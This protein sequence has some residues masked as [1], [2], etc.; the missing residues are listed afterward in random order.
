[1]EYKCHKSHNVCTKPDSFQMDEQPTDFE[2]RFSNGRRAAAQAH[3][4]DAL[5]H[6]EA[7]LKEARRVEI[8]DNRLCELLNC[9]TDSYQASY[10]FAEAKSSLNEAVDTACD[11]F[12]ADS[13]QAVPYLQKQGWFLCRDGAL[14]ESREIYRR[15][16][17]TKQAVLGATHND[18]G[19]LY[20]EWANVEW[21]WGEALVAQS[22]FDKAYEILS[23]NLALDDDELRELIEQ[24]A[25]FL[26]FANKA[27]EA[28][29]LVNQ[30]LD[31]LARAK[32]RRSTITALQVKL[33]DLFRF[34]GEYREHLHE[35]ITR[36]LSGFSPLA[37]SRFWVQLGDQYAFPEM[38]RTKALAAYRKSLDLLEDVVGTEHV[39]LVEPLERIVSLCLAQE[40]SYSI[41]CCERIVAI[42]EKAKGSEHSDTLNALVTLAHKHYLA[43]NYADANRLY[44]IVVERFDRYKCSDKCPVTNALISLAVSLHKTK[45]FDRSNDCLDRAEKILQ[46]LINTVTANATVGGF[47]F[48]Q[49][50]RIFN[51]KLRNYRA[52]NDIA[53]ARLEEEKL[54]SIRPG[55][56]WA[57]LI[58][59]HKRNKL[60]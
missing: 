60:F 5:L 28:A 22:H 34:T 2:S 30:Y 36:D 16:V 49:L 3:H 9:L 58:S 33:C 54:A 32:A 40:Q 20:R 26:L 10:M 38:Q 42:L 19:R 21:L 37:A 13:I 29:K 14:T 25:D 48:T 24:I 45:E 46:P 59:L 31:K 15:C 52:T 23:V 51:Q 53:K 6:F 7:A 1:M 17:S 39:L 12:G 41:H 18:I 27:T 57:L 11:F 4:E 43:R 55:N 44:E 8:R 35:Q 56:T 47:L 50:G